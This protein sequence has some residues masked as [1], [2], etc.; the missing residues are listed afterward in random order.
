VSD[1]DLTPSMLERIEA[2]EARQ[3][4]ERIHDPDCSC[5]DEFDGSVWLIRPCDCWLSR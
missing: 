3:R 1:T 4:A 2:I 5:R